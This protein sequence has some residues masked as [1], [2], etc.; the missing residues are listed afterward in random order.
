MFICAD[1]FAGDVDPCIGLRKKCDYTKFQKM[2]SMTE[3]YMMQA[4]Y[5]DRTVKNRRN[6]IKVIMNDFEKETKN[7]PHVFLHPGLLAAADE[8]LGNCSAAWAPGYKYDMADW[9]DPFEEKR[10]AAYAPTELPAHTQRLRKAHAGT[11]HISP[12]ERVC[13]LHVGLLVAIRAV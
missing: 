3:C 8:V 7:D 13:G 12:R 11:T 5:V 9:V 4:L 1:T 6:A 10:A 2:V